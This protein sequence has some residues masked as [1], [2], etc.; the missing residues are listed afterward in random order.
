LQDWNQAARE[1]LVVDHPGGRQGE[2]RPAQR[3]HYRRIMVVRSQPAVDGSVDIAG[4]GSKAPFLGAIEEGRDYAVVV[5]EVPGL[6]W[7]AAALEI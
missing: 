7:F 5:F 6:C 1:D 4:L 2:S 3:R